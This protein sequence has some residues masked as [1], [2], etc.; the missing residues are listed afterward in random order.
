MFSELW[1]KK[2]VMKNVDVAIVGGG[3]IGCFVGSRI[4][5]EGFSV[6]LFEEHQNFGLPLRC[7]G[8]V[9]D[10]VLD[11]LPSDADVVLNRVS[12]AR[13]HSPDG[14][15]VEIG[16]NKPRAFVIDRT[17]FDRCLGQVAEQ[18]GVVANLGC[19]VS[20]FTPSS[21]R[22]AVEMKGSC[23]EKYKADLFIGADGPFSVVRRCSGFSEPQSFLYGVGAQLSHVS[24]DPDFVHIF[25]G[26]DIAP[27]F[28]CWIIPTDESG[29]SARV[30]LC[31]SSQ[32]KSALSSCFQKIMHSSLLKNASI[33]GHIGGVIPLGP[34]KQTTDDSVMLVGDAAAQVKPTSGGGLYPGLV[35]GRYCAAVGVDALENEEYSNMSLHRYHR[36]WYEDVGRELSMGMRMR[37]WFERL[38]DESF[39]KG[40]ELIDSKKCLSAINRYGDIDYPSKVAYRM[41]GSCPGLLRLLPQAMFGNVKRWFQGEEPGGGGT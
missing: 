14:R 8:L 12:G 23:F 20:S 24:L 4:A 15:I 38:D 39:E 19:K 9:T 1:E 10:R 7:A 37:N 18:E 21:R 22:L 34:L 33:D 41:L 36:L 30:G 32:Y 31:V 17:G 29:K 6:S 40:L 3:P 27:G 11:F 2:Q 16:G 28:F 26:K 25:V 5:K 35:C 13:I